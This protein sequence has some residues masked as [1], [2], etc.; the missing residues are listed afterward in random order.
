MKVD[1]PNWCVET[2]HGVVHIEAVPNAATDTTG[3]AE[4]VDTADP[5]PGSAHSVQH[6]WGRIRPGSVGLMV[7]P[8]FLARGLT[9]GACIGTEGCLGAV[10]HLGILTSRPAE[11]NASLSQVLAA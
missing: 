3:Q 9:R 8:F 7:A 11:T 6:A 4:L 1:C 5:Q 2:Q 10:M